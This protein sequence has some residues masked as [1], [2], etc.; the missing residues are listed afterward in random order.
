[1]SAS[2]G[3]FLL[4]RNTRLASIKLIEWAQLAVVVS[5]EAYRV[6]LDSAQFTL[7]SGARGTIDREKLIE[8]NDAERATLAYCYF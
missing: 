7:E 3:T 1:V 6:Y 4:R 5:R 2:L 8:R